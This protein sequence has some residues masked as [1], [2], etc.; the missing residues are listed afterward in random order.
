MA[1]YDKRTEGLEQ[2][3]KELEHELGIAK[4]EKKVRELK[5]QIDEQ[6]QYPPYSR[7]PWYPW[8]PGWPTNPWCTWIDTSSA[9]AGN[10][11]EVDTAIWMLRCNTG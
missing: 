2:E 1:Y 8:H 6:K 11:V 5:E 9:T 4:L 7:N 3:I 10:A